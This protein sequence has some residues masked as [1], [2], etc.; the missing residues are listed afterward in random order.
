MTNY[1]LGLFGLLQHGDRVAIELTSSI[2]HPE[3][4]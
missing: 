1:H 2:G 4:P 3:A